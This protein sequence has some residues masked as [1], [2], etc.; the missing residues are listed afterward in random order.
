MKAAISR[1][2]CHPLS[3]GI[4]REK[5][6]SQPAVFLPSHL[7]HV[8]E[9]PAAQLSPP[10][11]KCIIPIATHLC[12]SQ[13]FPRPAVH[14]RTY[15][16]FPPC[17]DFQCPSIRIPDKKKV[18]KHWFAAR[19]VSTS[20]QP[21]EKERRRAKKKNTQDTRQPA[22]TRNQVTQT[23]MARLMSRHVPHLS[24]GNPSPSRQ[25]TNI[26]FTLRQWNTN[27]WMP[28]SFHPKPARE[29]TRSRAVSPPKRPYRVRCPQ[30]ERRKKD[31]QSNPNPKT[32]SLHHC[33]SP[34]VPGRQSQ[35]LINSA[36][37]RAKMQ[38]AFRISKSRRGPS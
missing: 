10:K 31:L 37:Y 24:L 23:R 2:A 12:S 34:P 18:L 29:P 6:H 8:A 1:R 35:F 9:L 32:P 33:S 4:T 38:D 15:M 11:T 5:K 13:D 17:Q 21:V 16:T 26:S 27:P 25:E 19:G 36:L 14:L 7:Q 20:H 28:S 3:Q 30:T 22:V